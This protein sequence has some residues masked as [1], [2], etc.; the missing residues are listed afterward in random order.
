ME[1][2]KEGRLRVS[3]STT[4]GPCS[5]NDDVFASVGENMRVIAAVCDGVYDE[6]G[7]GRKAAEFVTSKLIR[8]ENLHI[9][10][11]DE[12]LECINKIN[13]ELYENKE[14]GYTT[15]AFV[16]MS[17]EERKEIT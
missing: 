15:L 4:N 9:A 2:Y 8:R 13:D 11:M 16:E 14:A 7:A 1:L 3:A 17:L 12:W 10:A 5:Y 6:N